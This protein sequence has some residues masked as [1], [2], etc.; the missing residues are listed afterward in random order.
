MACGL[1]VLCSI[2]NGCYPELVHDGRNGWRFDP[3][4]AEDTYQ[5]LARC[6]Q[7]YQRLPAMGEES[8]RMVEA[9]TPECAADAILEACRMAH[10][11]LSREI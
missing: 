4:D 10:T 6:V 11:R 1:P 8:R 2:Y 9:Y 3:I 7:S 5:A